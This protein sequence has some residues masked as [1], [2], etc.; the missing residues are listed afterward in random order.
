MVLPWQSSKDSVLLLQGAWVLS[1]VDVAKKKKNN[2][3]RNKHFSNNLME[4]TCGGKTGSHLKHR[5]MG[6]NCT[7]GPCTLKKKSFLS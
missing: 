5:H 3:P 1:Q 7:I 6:K 4:I 2:K